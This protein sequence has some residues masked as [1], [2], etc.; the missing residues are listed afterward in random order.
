[1]P[2]C[3]ISG[4]CLQI[5][6]FNS[7][8]C[9][10]VREADGLTLID[11]AFGAARIIVEAA[12]HLQQPIRRILLTHAHFDHVGSLD[13]LKKL[14]PDAEVLAG[15]R[16]SLVLK[17]AARGV[18]A[19][20]MT[21]L[22]EEPQTPVKGSFKKLKNL[23]GVLLHEGERV[24]SLQV[25][26][27]AGHTPGH[28]SFFDERDGSLYAGDAM[29]NIKELRLPYDPP[30]YFPLPKWAT[31]HHQ[32]ALES[33]QRLFD[34]HC[35]RVLPGHGKAVEKPSKAFEHALSRVRQKVTA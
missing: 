35:E 15:N 8:N 16:E 27:S 18:K 33:A 14:V 21:L 31:W 10:L 12:R 17:E 26:K 9:Y 2:V 1:M 25:I 6:R 32:T 5:K 28:L 34:L 20:R 24:G 19:A 23:P 30:W 13:A 7:V 4:N 3:Q 29:V 22:P 11:T